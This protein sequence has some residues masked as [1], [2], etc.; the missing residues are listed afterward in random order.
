MYVDITSTHP[1]NVFYS[2]SNRINLETLPVVLGGL[3][4]VVQWFD[5]HCSFLALLS[6]CDITSGDHW[7]LI[8]IWLASSIGDVFEIQWGLVN[9][10]TF[11][12]SVLRRLHGIGCKGTRSNNNLR[13]EENWLQHELVWLGLS[14]E[15]EKSN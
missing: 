1:L 14:S 2:I 11:S 7:S 15:K 6:F 3:F 12:A 10:R 9:G 8:Q 4:P 5:T 13:I